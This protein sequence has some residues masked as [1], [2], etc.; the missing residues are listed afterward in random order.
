MQK[1]RPETPLAWI[2][3]FDKSVIENDLVEEPLCQIL[4]LLIVVTLAPK[5]AV[6]GLPVVLKEQPDQRPVSVVFR[7]DISYER[8]VGGQELMVLSP[9]VCLVIIS[10]GCSIQAIAAEPTVV[11]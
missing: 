6:D 11:R 2:G 7:L 10:H 5:I 3:S 8:P 4:R 9:D 1:K